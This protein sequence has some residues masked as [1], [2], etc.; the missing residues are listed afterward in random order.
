MIRSY[1][2]IS[3]LLRKNMINPFVPDATFVYPLKTPEKVFWCFQGVEKGCI[4]NEW[5]NH[6]FV[7]FNVVNHK[8][9]NIKNLE[10]Y[11][12]LKMFTTFTEKHRVLF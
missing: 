7:I 2:W 6:D 12:T 10:K 1:F 9:A 8:Q 11:E 5:I 3:G 4:G